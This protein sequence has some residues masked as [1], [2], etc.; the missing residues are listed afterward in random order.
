MATN[1]KQPRPARE[2]KTYTLDELRTW[3]TH[4]LDVLAKRTENAR[5]KIG[6]S[7]ERARAREDALKAQ[8]KIIADAQAYAKQSAALVEV[9]ATSGVNITP[10]QLAELLHRHARQTVPVK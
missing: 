7:I 3:P 9:V 4:K 1:T 5:L 10:A 6:P 2:R 8:A